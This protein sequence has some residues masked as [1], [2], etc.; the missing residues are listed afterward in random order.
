MDY[1]G[2]DA[3]A[4]VVRVGAAGED[5]RDD[6]SVVVDGGAARV[7]GPHVHA[8]AGDDAL[9]RAVV[10]GVAGDDAFGRVPCGQARCRADRSRGTR[11]RPPSSPGWVVARG[12]G[13]EAETVYAQDGYVVPLV[14]DDDLGGQAPSRA[15]DLHLRRRLP[16]DHVGVGDDKVPASHPARALYAVAAGSCPSRAAY[17]RSPLARRDRPTMLPSGA[18]TSGSGPRI[19]GS[20]CSSATACV[21]SPEGIRSSR[22]CRILESCTAGCSPARGGD[23]RAKTPT[24]HTSTRERANPSAAPPSPSSVSEVGLERRF[25]IE[26]PIDL[27]MT[28][29]ST[30]KARMLPRVIPAP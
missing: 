1:S 29:P 26:P 13:V 14:E 4:R 28:S 11:S 5:G 7:A 23:W 30:A 20:G 3:V 12:S 10:V 19:L 8:E 22:A 27:A 16:G 24:A 25:L 18:A 15:P 2:G 6:P 21:R 17:A 9:H